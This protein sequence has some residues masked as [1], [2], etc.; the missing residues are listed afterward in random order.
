MT[1]ENNKVYSNTSSTMRNII[2]ML[3]LEK[4]YLDTN[5]T[6]ILSE[7]TKLKNDIS[8]LTFRQEE[9]VEELKNLSKRFLKLLDF[10]F[11]EKKGISD[12]LKNDVVSKKKLY[13][14]ELINATLSDLEF[15]SI[16]F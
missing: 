16:Y 1:I 13:R 6:K 7:M 15:L 2:S 3:Y 8:K 11:D 9:E 10:F 5:T 12:F 14:Q 4:M